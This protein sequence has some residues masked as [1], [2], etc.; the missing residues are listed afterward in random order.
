MC[1]CVNMLMCQWINVST[2]MPMC[3]CVY[4]PYLWMNQWA[5]V[6]DNVDVSVYHDQWFYVSVSQ[7]LNA[8]MCQC[9]NVSMKPATTQSLACT[10]LSIGASGLF[11]IS[12]LPSSLFIIPACHSSISFLF[13]SPSFSCSCEPVLFLSV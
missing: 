11:F 5:N 12:Q 6:N 1:Q 7:C 3:Q 10:Y 9:V 13:V 2:S 4:V 8:L